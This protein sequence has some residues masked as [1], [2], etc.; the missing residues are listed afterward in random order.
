M[1]KLRLDWA[2]GAPRLRT[3]AA[4][5]RQ[6][7]VTTVSSPAGT[8]AVVGWVGSTRDRVAGAHGLLDAFGRPGTAPQIST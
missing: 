8:A 1:E 2:D 3:T 7:L 5:A 4:L 6:G